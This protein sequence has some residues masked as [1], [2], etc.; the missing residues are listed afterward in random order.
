MKTR[1]FHLWIILVA[2]ASPYCFSLSVQAQE[3]GLPPLPKPKTTPTPRP[4]VTATPKPNANNT[5]TNLLREPAAI[6]PLA[7]NQGAEGN[8]DA[9][10]AGRLTQTSYY[11]EYIVMATGG[12]LF[13]IRLQSANPGLAVQVFDKEKA[14][15]PILK[16]PRTGEFKLDTPDGT[17]PG[18]GEYR[19]RVLGALAEAN[20]AP[21]A[22][23]LN[24]NLTGWTEDGY[25]ARLQQ[26][27]SAFN[28]PGEKKVNEAIAQLEQLAHEDAGKPGA[29]EHLGVLYLYHRSDLAKA[30][31]QME[32]AIKLG[33]SASFQITHDRQW[34]QP[35]KQGQTFNWDDQRISWFKIRSGQIE[36]TDSSESPQT[37]LSTSG[38]QIKG[39]ERAGASAVIEIKPEGARNKSRYF[40]PNT[41]NPAEAEA[42]VNLMK[43][44]ILGKG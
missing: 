8:L 44:H 4:K 10:T 21:I 15:L 1:S 37:L 14:G 41:K 36:V 33:G 22:Y 29:Y 3:S 23:K 30:L 40:A 39:I 38:R 13:T 31:A 32:Q 42:I 26:I 35:R 6:A 18:D 16:D 5:P 24:L 27:I 28:A 19:V 9:K 17:L 20:A 11:D 25:R 34:R 2:L 12:E 43:T 7:F